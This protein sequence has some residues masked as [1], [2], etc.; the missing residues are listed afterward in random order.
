[1]IIKMLVGFAV[2]LGSLVVIL[3]APPAGADPNPFGGLT[4]NCQSTT[5][6]GPAAAREFARG[7]N[8]ALTR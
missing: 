6:A 1:M 7:I 3:G 2:I 4:C 5:P 8:S